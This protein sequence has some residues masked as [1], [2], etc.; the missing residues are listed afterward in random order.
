MMDQ[1][2]KKAGEDGSI[3][4]NGQNEPVLAE[5]TKAQHVEVF[6]VSLLVAK[7]LGDFL[8]IFCLEVE[9]DEG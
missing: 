1:H 5:F 4:R 3:W 7:R 2:S 6:N 8:V 9:E